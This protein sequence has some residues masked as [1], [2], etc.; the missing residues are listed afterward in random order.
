M[1]LLYAT[2]EIDVVAVKQRTGG[3]V[4]APVWT[5]VSSATYGAGAPP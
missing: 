5:T 1:L 4:E 2:K 3:T